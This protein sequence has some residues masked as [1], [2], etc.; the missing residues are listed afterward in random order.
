MLHL[1]NS[2]TRLM[3]PFEA[4]NGR[5]VKMFSCGPSIYRRPHVGNYRTF[6]WEDALQRYLEYLGYDVRRVLNFTDVEDKAIE[7][8]RQ[9]GKAVGELT[10]AVADRFTA[11]ARMLGIKLPEKI[12][13]S[14]TSVQQ[15]AALI[16]RLLASGH[17]YRYEGN[18]FFDPLKFKSFGKLFRLDMSR[19]PREKRRFKKDTYPGQRWNLGDF[20]LWHGAGEGDE[21]YWDT[22]IGKG[23]PAWNIQDPAMI[24]ETLGYDLDIFCGGIDNMWRHHDYN[25]A[26]MESLSGEELARFWLHGEHVLAGGKKMSKSLSNIVYPEDLVEQGRGGRHI[27][28]YLLS[29]QYRKRLN[30]TMDAF[31]KSCAKLDAFVSMVGDILEQRGGTRFAVDEGVEKLIAELTTRFEAGMND[32]LDT[33]KALEGVAGT[34]AGLH[35]L[36]K[37]G[38]IGPDQTRAIEAGL[39]RVDSVLRVIFE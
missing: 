15:A 38:R 24:S 10:G 18:I 31:R 17:A 34:V 25:I 23:R 5:M 6:I 7:E 27:R 30:L 16:S 20:I 35:G 22:E 39:R 9:D 3:E 37:A 19:W 21:I 1:L 33:H 11:E 28:F 2:M 13:R 36:W 26:V 4:R 32:D 8:A 14:S 29:T 12:P